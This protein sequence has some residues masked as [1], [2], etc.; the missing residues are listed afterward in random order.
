MK[1]LFPIDITSVSKLAKL[2]CISQGALSNIISGK[3]RPGYKLAKK[4]ELITGVHLE[5]WLGGSHLQLQ[6]ELGIIGTSNQISKATQTLEKN[7]YYFK[8][9]CKD[10]LT[11][12]QGELYTKQ[13]GNISMVSNRTL[14]G[15]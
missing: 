12:G 6:K 4:L 14:T 2:A 11:Y 9:E 1:L 8:K 3:R 7:I 5:I 15:L 13:P 10:N